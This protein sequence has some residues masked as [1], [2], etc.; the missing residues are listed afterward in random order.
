MTAFDRTKLLYLKNTYSV[1][2]RSCIVQTRHYSLLQYFEVKQIEAVFRRCIFAIDVPKKFRKCHRKAPVFESF[3]NIVAGLKACNFTEKRFQCRCFLVKFVNFLRAP[4]FTEHLQW[5][6]LNKPGDRSLWFI[7]Q[8][9]FYDHL[10][11]LYLHCPIS[12]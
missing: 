10:T 12:C 2:T 8:S 4:Y 6:L 5:L 1:L 9:N 11:Q 7:Q 3:F